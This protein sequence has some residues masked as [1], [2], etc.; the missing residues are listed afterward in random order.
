[1]MAAEAPD[2]KLMPK[3]IRPIWVINHRARIIKPGH[4]RISGHNRVPRAIAQIAMHTTPMAKRKNALQRGGKA[5][6]PIFTATGL[7]PQR[8]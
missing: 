7:A 4:S 2:V 1:M 6:N 3:F 5:T 8:M